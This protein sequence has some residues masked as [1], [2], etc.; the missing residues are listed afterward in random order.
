MIA[1]VRAGLRAAAAQPKLPLLV[2]GW[3][4]LLALV[5]ILPV[6]SAWNAVLGPSTE[7]RKILRRFDISVYADLVRDSAASAMGSPLRGLIAA[8]AVAAISSAFVF[9]GTVE[10]LGRGGEP[11]PFL[12]RFF[13]GGGRYFGR[14]LRLAL[15]A[16]ASAFL[17]AGAVSAAVAG[18]L[19]PLGGSEWEPA[20]YLAAA[21]TAAAALATAGLFLL[22]LD[23]ARI[24][25][26]RDGSR[27]MLKAYLGGLGFTL[28]N[29]ASVFGVAIAFALMLAALALA[30][31]AYEAN[32]PAA[33]SWGAIAAL[34]IVMQAIVFGRVFLRVAMVGAE[35]HLD[36][37]RRPAARPA[38][39]EPSPGPTSPA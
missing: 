1:S 28:R 31:L 30:Y 4:A 36:L 29:L 18:A 6:F 16:A 2:W 14:F 23:Y 15:V 13:S 21:V 32:T 27:G 7:A 10:I 24:Q 11:G 38:P 8:L 17:A 25:V 5:P 39:A 9:G 19:S 12:Q 3:Y 26:A 33:G 22:A 37:A 20:R 34:S 35:R